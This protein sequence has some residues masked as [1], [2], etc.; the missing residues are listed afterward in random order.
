MSIQISPLKPDDIIIV[1]ETTH[2][3]ITIKLFPEQTPKTCENFI[4]LVEQGYYDGIIF[5]RI[6]TD[7]MIQWGDPTGTGMGGKSIFGKNFEDEF[8]PELK[9]IRWALSM[10]NAG[11]NTNGSQFF[12]VHAESTPWLDNHHTV[13]GQVVEGWKV[14][15]DIAHEKTDWN[16]KPVGD[17]RIL[18]ATVKS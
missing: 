16:N 2:G 4:K 8:H 12:I 10:A 15:D 7:F 14:V 1:M 11:R 6:I 5:H 9:N 3:T 18:K 17:V 13:F